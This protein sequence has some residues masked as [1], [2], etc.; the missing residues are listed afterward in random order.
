MMEVGSYLKEYYCLQECFHNR[1][2]FDRGN[3]YTER[4]VLAGLR[5][6][7]GGPDMEAQPMTPHLIQITPPLQEKNDQDRKKIRKALED[8]ENEEKDYVKF[9]MNHPAI[10]DRLK[11][12]ASMREKLLSA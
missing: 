10:Q 2:H 8:L 12:I 4:K 5:D 6:K 11:F 3:I 1:Q 9:G 7:N